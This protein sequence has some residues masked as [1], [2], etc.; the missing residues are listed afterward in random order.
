MRSEIWRLVSPSPINSSTR[1]DFPADRDTVPV[2][3]PH[4]EN[5]HVR[6]QCGHPCHGRR[7]GVRLADYLDVRLGVEQ[8]PYAPPEDFVVIHQEHADP[9][10]LWAV[11]VHP[12]SPFRAR[13]RHG[14]WH[15]STEAASLGN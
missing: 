14:Q 8:G 4:I 6:P 1:A 5:R 15:G 12:H 10:R 11:F 7:R 3:Q 2:R 13:R 9:A